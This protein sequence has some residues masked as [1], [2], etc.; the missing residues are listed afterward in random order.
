MRKKC[1][2]L[3]IITLVAVTAIG[4][5]Q[6]IASAHPGAGKTSL[7]TIS[8]DPEEIDPDYVAE[9]DIKIPALTEDEEKMALEIA[10]G[11]PRVQELLSGK[12]Y[13]VCAIGVVHTTE[14]VKTGAGILLCL[15]KAYEIEYDWPYTVYN[16]KLSTLEDKVFH[17]NLSVQTL[18]VIVNFQQKKVEV[19]S[20]LSQNI[21]M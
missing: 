12:K 8:I 3:L 6:G 18:R 13:E 2:M 11:D 1:L 19:I 21:N 20:P 4:V 7:R 14:L 9:P 17:E 16:D 15:D 10:L 5:G